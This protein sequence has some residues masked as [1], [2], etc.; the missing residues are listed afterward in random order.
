MITSLIISFK[1]GDEMA[2]KIAQIN[3]PINFL[4]ISIYVEK[5]IVEHG[6]LTQGTLFLT[7]NFSPKELINNEKNSICCKWNGVFWM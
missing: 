2:K 4:L 6:I 3:P 5:P 7:K 1:N